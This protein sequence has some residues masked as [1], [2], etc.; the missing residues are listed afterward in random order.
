MSVNMENRDENSIK[1]DAFISYRHCELDQY[2]AVTLQ[3]KLENFKL[4]KSALPK[5][6][7]E[8]TKITRVFRD[9]DE[10]M[11]SDNLSEPIDYA[12]ANSEFLIVVC[13]PRL[14]LSKWCLREIETFLKA[15]DRKHILLVLAE[16]EPSESFPEILC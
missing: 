14:S 3:K 16:G 11:L 15:H 4:P 1:Y 10:L 5:V 8:K 6:K 2:V 7:G 12:L 9:E 13:S